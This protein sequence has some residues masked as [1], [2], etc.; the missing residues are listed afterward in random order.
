LVGWINLHNHLVFLLKVFVKAYD[1]TKE[2]VIFRL[3]FLYN[4]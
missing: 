3:P 1:H 4:Y 2:R